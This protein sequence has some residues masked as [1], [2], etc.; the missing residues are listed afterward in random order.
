[1]QITGGSAFKDL[2]GETLVKDTAHACADDTDL[3]ELLRASV[4]E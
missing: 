4:S 2:E 1:M 3:L